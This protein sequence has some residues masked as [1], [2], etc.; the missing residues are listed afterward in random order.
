MTH[1]A[2]ELIDTIEIRQ[3]LED[4]LEVL[5]WRLNAGGFR[6]EERQVFERA[7]RLIKEG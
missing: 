2:T 4:L 7:D 6:D 3:A 5:R 1:P